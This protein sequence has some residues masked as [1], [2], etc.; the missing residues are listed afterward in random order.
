V[1]GAYSNNNGSVS[2]DTNS[3]VNTTTDVQNPY[4]PGFGVDRRG[5]A[6]NGL[7]A[8]A[9]SSRYDAVEIAVERQA[10]LD[11]G[12][13]GDPATLNFQVFT[14][15][16]GTQTGGAGDISG[17]N[18]IR[19]T[20]GDDWLA[21]DYWKDQDN[22]RLNGKLTSYFGRSSANDRGK[23]AKVM[24]LAHGNHSIQPGSTMQS[25]VNDGAPTGA[26]GYSRMLATHEAYNAPLTLH[27]TPTLAS[28]LQWAKNPTGGAAND[29]P[30][31][32]TRI[33]NQIS[34]GRIQ[35]LGSTF[36]DHIPKYFPQAFNNSN[37][38]LAETFL[39]SVYGN[40]S[41]TASRQAFWTPERVLDDETLAQISGMGYGYTFADQM[42]HF[43]KW[44]GRTSAL[45]TDGFRINQVNGVKIFP[46]HDVTSEYLDQ[47][48]DEGST[49]AVRELLSRRSRSS[50]QD[51]LVV[52]WRDMGDFTNNAKASSYDTNVRWL[53]SRPW[54]RVVTAGQII[55][56]QV[57]YKGTDGNTYTTWST[58]Q[59]GSGLNLVQTAKDWI[60]HAT[61]ENY[62][63]WYNGSGF[64]Q[65]L[66]GRSFGA[67]TPFGQV[68][69]SGH[70][71][72]VWQTLNGAGLSN[73]LGNLANTVFH[74]AMFQTAFHN[75]TN[76]DLSKFSTGAYIYPD[77]GTG[78]TLA[79]FARNSQAQARFA[80]VYARVQQWAASA[81][82]STLGAEAVDVDLDGSAEYLLYNRRVFALFEAK[83]GRMTAAWMRD[84][85]S[86]RLWQ[87]A[88]N[89]ASYSGTDTEDEGASNFVGATTAISAYRTS[90]FKDWWVVDPSN[91]GSNS[92]VNATYTVAPAATGTGWTFTNGG[93]SKTIR[94]PGTTSERLQA[95]YQ[96]SGLNKAYVRFG[97]SPNLLDLM[98]RGQT[99]LGDE[100]VTATRANLT[101]TSGGDIV[102]AFVEGPQINASAS[103]IGGSTFTTV[104]RRN[105]A[106]THQVEVE[107]T[108]A[109]PHT[110][111]F[112][113]D[114]G[115]DL[116]DLDNDGLPDSWEN[117]NGLSTGDD[118]SIN[119]DNGSNGD[120]DHD[121]IL[122]G[123]EWLVG[124]NPQL[125]D[126]SAYPKL[127]IAKI[128]GG[129]RVSFPTLPGR[130]Y[131]VQSS[132]TLNA[133]A[134]FGSPLITAPNDPPG[135]FQIDDTTGLPKRFYRMVVTPAP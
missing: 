117:S 46:I 14:T 99:G 113:F 4:D 63:N 56:G 57:A 80:N 108:G 18:D 107:L 100:Q 112:G 12:W 36:S 65:G 115:T 97:L 30:A 118:G 76:N 121:G 88:G 122:N 26:A 93:V 42:R 69:S 33:A 111:S 126:N 85:A 70:A 52:L 81:T 78:Q 44:F 43:V 83:G 87:V 1:V 119:I 86:G 38:A 50:I 131:Q 62:N 53:S 64:E 120:P 7:N 110:I 89:F 24:L 101:D 61:Q 29:G 31:L 94:L 125:I 68:G 15:K 127:A 45:G 104:L 72:S 74:G 28:A 16:D 90:G 71:D 21:S 103:D 66:A 10:L 11:A 59:R 134:P 13:L 49:Q 95:T 55:N 133:W 47:T 48:L 73:G 132:T 5:I 114:L 79:D 6:A 27:V 17:R 60:D 109:G 92:G 2:V 32:N 75:T 106:Q 19:D 40:G 102:R 37:K 128:T 20:I 96:L 35:L 23:A 34:N 116:T 67:T 129:F 51:Q 77:T 98:L 22:I 124:L 41:P 91:T 9:W 82:S 130:T 39:D 58:T 3:S 84:P 54:I 105:Q 123:I 135:T 8:I 25:L